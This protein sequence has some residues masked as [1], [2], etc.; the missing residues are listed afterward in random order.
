MNYLKKS[1]KNQMI[2]RVLKTDSTST[3]YNDLVSCLNN[4]VTL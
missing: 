1:E 3:N 2:K 4:L